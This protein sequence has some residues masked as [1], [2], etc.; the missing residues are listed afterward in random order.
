[1]HGG[2]EPV[3]LSPGEGSKTLSKRMEIDEEKNSVWFARTAEAA[4]MIKNAETRSF[5]L[6]D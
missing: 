6:L 5:T 1:L 2:L 4:K 3:F